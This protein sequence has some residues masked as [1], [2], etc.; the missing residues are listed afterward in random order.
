MTLGQLHAAIDRLLDEGVPASTQVLVK[1][2]T[3]D[4]TSSPHLTVDNPA[5]DDRTVFLE[6]N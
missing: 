3:D 5:D 1:D 6:I 4:F 2:M